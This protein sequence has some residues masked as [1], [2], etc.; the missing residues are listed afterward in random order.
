MKTIKDA[1]LEEISDFSKIASP[2]VKFIR[3]NW[4][5]DVKPKGY[6][7]FMDDYEEYKGQGEDQYELDFVG[8][9]WERRNLI[10]ELDLDLM[11]GILSSNKRLKLIHEEGSRSPAV[12]D[13]W[14]L[15]LRL[16]KA[17]QSTL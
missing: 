17:L 2:L 10:E 8:L 13:L 15:T 7:E 1:T 14:D 12:K 11:I 16:R 4:S 9:L 5:T 3:D 6:D